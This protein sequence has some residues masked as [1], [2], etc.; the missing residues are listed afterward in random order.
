MYGG[1]YKSSYHWESVYTPFGPVQASKR[2][3][4]L[5][6]S[7]FNYPVIFLSTF[8]PSSKH[9]NYNNID[10]GT[11]I[12]STNRSNNVNTIKSYRD[13]ASRNSS[14]STGDSKPSTPNAVVSS[15]TIAKKS[16]ITTMATA[17]NQRESDIV[18]NGE[19]AKAEMKGNLNILS[20]SLDGN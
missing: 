2:A 1:S 13:V 17:I 3:N 15:P 10:N 20:K 7:V 12:D 14:T 6:V 18:T 8:Q 19:H 11:L 9:Y 16:M 4:Q 5:P